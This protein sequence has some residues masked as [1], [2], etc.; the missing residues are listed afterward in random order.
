[1]PKNCLVGDKGIIK[2]SGFTVQ[3]E[4]HNKINANSKYRLKWFTRLRSSCFGHTVCSMLLMKKVHLNIKNQG[5]RQSTSDVSDTNMLDKDIIYNFESSTC[6]NLSLY[7]GFE[8]NDKIFCH[9]TV[10]GQLQTLFMIE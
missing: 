2:I 4:V 5:Q 1:M 9:G 8:R 10:K 3:G 6:R 7:L